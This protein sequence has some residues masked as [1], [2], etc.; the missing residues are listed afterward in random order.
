MAA[1]TAGSVRRGAVYPT[2]LRAAVVLPSARSSV[3]CRFLR[4]VSR[5]NRPAG[6]Y[7][8]HRQVE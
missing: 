8:R 5:I 2:A 3:S 7:I 6:A 1:A 4:P